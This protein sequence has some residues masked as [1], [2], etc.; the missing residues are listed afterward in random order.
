MPVLPTAELLEKVA[1]A[2][3]HAHEQGLVHRDLKPANILLQEAKD[4]QG[5]N[6]P[7]PKVADFGLAKLLTDDSNLSQSGAVV[8]TPCYMAPEQAL[9]KTAQVGPA[10]D[11][12]S[13][14]AILYEMLTGQPPFH[15][16]SSV[17]TLLNVVA[18]DPVPPSQLQ[19]RVPRDL[20]TICLKCLEKEPRRRYA[21]A[22][23]LA[24]DL[25]RFLAGVPIM[26]RPVGPV[27]RLWRWGRRNPI[28]A[29]LTAAML[30]C[31]VVGTIVSTSFGIESRARAVQALS[32]K[33]R[34]DGEARKALAEQKRADREAKEA[35]VQEQQAKENALRA[36]RA[37]AEA[38][39]EKLKAQRLAA[40]LA[41]DHGLT[42]CSQGQADH[43]LLWLARSLEV[44][45]SNTDDLQRSIRANLATWRGHLHSL[46]LDLPHPDWVTAAA[47]SP[48]GKRILTAGRDKLARFWDSTTGDPVGKPL[49]HDGPIR[50]AAFHPDGQTVAT[51]SGFVVRLWKT[52]SGQLVGKPLAHRFRVDRMAYSPD[53]RFLLTATAL[54]TFHLWDAKTGKSLKF[55]PAWENA[56]RPPP[57]RAIA[58]TSDGTTLLAAIGSSVRF[59]DVATGRFKQDPLIH[60]AEVTAVAVSPDAK[61]VLTGCTDGSV[62]RW[63][64]AT[65]K[66]LG[67]PLARPGRRDFG[68]DWP[69]WQAG[70][71]RRPRL[72]RVLV[73]PGHRPASW[74]TV[75]AQ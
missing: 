10:T 68:G 37:N 53:G 22:A 71:D 31:L 18:V 27:E 26:A 65:G 39:Q 72:D 69:G 59:W 63:D 56:Q 66:V 45:P 43:G 32:E 57:V 50:T 47:F 67:Q 17:D 1:R 73:G 48:D 35:L 9:G 29:G 11:T 61:T 54:S 64:L 49:P 20:E 75:A 33:D 3:H 42:L 34:A 19:P 14:G 15:G 7:W 16:E 40:V 41:L 5:A 62:R 23:A 6:L 12:Y 25:V 44:A 46:R 51:S 8:G 2:V 36:E 28:L 4:P 70:N 24:E 13:L 74:T 55:D 21:S 38:Q 58:F 30:L 60:P 52:S